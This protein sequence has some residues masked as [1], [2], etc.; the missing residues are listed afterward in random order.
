MYFNVI[1]SCLQKYYDT[2]F[3][4]RNQYYA[5]QIIENVYFG[6]DYYDKGIL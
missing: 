5:K 3:S 4:L 6:A 2:S 1:N